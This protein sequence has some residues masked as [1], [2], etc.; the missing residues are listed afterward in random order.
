MK[1]NVEYFPQADKMV[2]W[3]CQK[4]IGLNEDFMAYPHEQGDCLIQGKD[5]KPKKV[6]VKCRACH[7]KDPHLHFQKCEV[8][9]RIVGYIRPVEQWNKGKKEEWKDR[10]PYK[11]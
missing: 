2:C 8:Y 3:D 1:E 10:T 4:E 7:T 9:S 6:F 5:G 11:V